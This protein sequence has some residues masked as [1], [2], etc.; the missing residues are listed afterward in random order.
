MAE[1]SILSIGADGRFASLVVPELVRRGAECVGSCIGQ[2]R[3]AS[4][5]ETTT[6]FS[7]YQHGVGTCRMAPIT[8]RNAVVNSA[9]AVHGVSHLHVIDASIMPSIPT[10]NTNLPTLML[11]ERLA[12]TWNLSEGRREDGLVQG[13]LTG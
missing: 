12:S 1:P 13:V 5:Q 2:K 4:I 10:A 3:P 11:A 9:G 8:D 7:S 6:S